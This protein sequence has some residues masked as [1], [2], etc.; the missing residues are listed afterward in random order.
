[1][2]R[3]KKTN[4]SNK[5]KRTRPST[6]MSVAKYDFEREIQT[7]FTKQDKMTIQQTMYTS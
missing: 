2:C 6:D 4:T 5:V 3:V 1:M 7:P